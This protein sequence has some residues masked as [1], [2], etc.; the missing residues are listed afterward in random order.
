MVKKMPNSK[1][2]PFLDHMNSKM[3]PFIKDNGVMD[4]DKEKVL[5][6]GLMEVSMKDIGKLIKPMEKE[7]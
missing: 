1:T 2:Y 5:K 7:D 3:V 4:K 6:A